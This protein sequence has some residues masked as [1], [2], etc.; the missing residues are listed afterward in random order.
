MR[1]LSFIKHIAL[2]G[3]LI[4]SSL[5][6]ANPSEADIR[7]IFPKLT[8]IGE[9]Q[10]NPP[11]LPVY[12]LD[13]LLGYIF[14]TND[15]TD[16]P[17]FSGERINMLIGLDPQGLVAGLKVLNH[18]EPIFMHGLGEKPM[19]GFVNQYKGLS[20]ASR[21]IVDSRQSGKDDGSGTVFIDGV[22]KATVSVLVMNDTVLASALKVARAY[23]DG[24]YQPPEAVVKETV[25]Q[26]YNW[27]ALLETKLV[28]S[29]PLSLT[30]L[31]Q[32]LPQELADY[33]D[34]ELEQLTEELDVEMGE[35]A[36]Q[37]FYTYLNTPVTGRNLLGDSE[38]GRLKQVLRPG[39]HALLVASTGMYSFLEP[40]FRR[41]TVPQRLGLQQN[42]LPVD[43]RDLDFFDAGMPDLGIPGMQQMRIFRIKAQSGFNPSQPITLTLNLDL[44]RNHLLRDQAQFESRHQMPGELF[45]IQEI[46][47][48]KPQP[49]WQRLWQDRIP[50]VVL[51]LVILTVV[52]AAFIWQH[53]LSAHSQLMHK[54]RWGV[55]LLTF[56]FIGIYAQGQLSVVNIYTLLLE[57]TN[58]FDLQVFLLDPVLFVL[59]SYVFI[60]LFLWGRGVFCGWLCPF[61]VLQEIVGKLAS[62]LKI[63]QWKVA[64]LWHKRLQKLKY[65]ILVVLVGSAFWSVSLAE[66]LA[67]IEPFKTT[68]TLYFD[69]SWPFVVYALLLLGSGLFIHKFFCRYLCPL[70]AGLSVL[71]RL[72][73]FRWLYRRR[74]CGSPCQLCKVRCEIDSI[75]RDGSVDYSECIQC[76]EC[77]VILNNPD[78]CAIEMSQNKQRNRQQ[79]NKAQQS[80]EAVQL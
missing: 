58:G 23:L 25:F 55:M 56:G 77:I 15:L 52:S 53:R 7:S 62:W 61:G 70:G 64:P 3:L 16:L 41:G 51:L 67:E 42:G 63:K 21:I 31:D 39:E 13:Q 20:V 24:F 22:T 37:Y 17:G 6:Q 44:A 27:Q 78:Q 18:H 71:G 40:G 45:D 28:K 57:L 1:C 65:L 49:L 36:G 43:I 19:V 68:I 34:P 32:G 26:P 11:V 50:Q 76:M 75:N 12:Q 46:V 35:L 79:R 4:F 38:F 8:R 72:S 14:E 54:V 59:W 10:Q 74:E 69:R 33:P 30:E 48:V 66:R 47:E 60:T 9:P 29:W 2:C 73:L 5:L 80:I